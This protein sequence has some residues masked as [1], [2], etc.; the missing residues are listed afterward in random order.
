MIPMEEEYIFTRQVKEIEYGGK[1]IGFFS[2]Y[3]GLLLLRGFVD[4]MEQMGWGVLV[5]T[6]PDFIVKSH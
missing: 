4:K 2:E 5:L 6:I 1:L 3:I